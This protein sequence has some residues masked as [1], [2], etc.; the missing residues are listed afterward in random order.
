MT[1]CYNIL[2]DTLHVAHQP[3]ILGSVLKQYVLFSFKARES[4]SKSKGIM[5]LLLAADSSSLYVQMLFVCLS[6]VVIKLRKLLANC[7]LTACMIL[8]YNREAC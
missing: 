5:L 4:S 7:L 1:S 3:N 6:V 8:Y 2:Y